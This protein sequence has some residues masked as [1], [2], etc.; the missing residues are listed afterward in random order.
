MRS[1]IIYLN[2]SLFYVPEG[3]LWNGRLVPF[4][5]LGI[6]ILG[7]K[8]LDLIFNE[9]VEYQQGELLTKLTIFISLSICL[10]IFYDKWSQYSSYNLFTFGV[11]GFSIFQLLK[12]LNSTFKLIN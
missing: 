6:I 12:L 8:I 7:F 3:A 11:I 2:F 5:N 1:I 9:I 4:F 10:Y